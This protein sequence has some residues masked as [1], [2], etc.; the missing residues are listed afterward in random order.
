MLRSNFG[1]AAKHQ[2]MYIIQDEVKPATF[3]W[4][5]ENWIWMPSFRALKYVQELLM[6]SS[7]LWM[8]SARPYEQ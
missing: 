8:C 1:K 6:L 2:P 5:F 7:A 4:L 3:T